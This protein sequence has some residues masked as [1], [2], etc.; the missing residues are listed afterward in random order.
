LFGLHKH[1]ESIDE[2]QRVQFFSTC[3]H[4]GYKQFECAAVTWT[5]WVIR[6]V[7]VKYFLRVF[8][9]SALCEWCREIL[10]VSVLVKYFAWVF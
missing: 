8:Y 6:V 1:S 4:C 9:W 3:E 2:Y 10:F 7:L 5:L